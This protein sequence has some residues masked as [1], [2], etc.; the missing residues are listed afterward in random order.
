M[1]DKS[2]LSSVKAF[3]ISDI[4]KLACLDYNSYYPPNDPEGHITPPK[5]YIG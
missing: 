4:K 1:C 3:K 2:L 5:P